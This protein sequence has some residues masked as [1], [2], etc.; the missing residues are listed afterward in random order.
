MTDEIQAVT[1]RIQKGQGLTQALLAHAKRENMKMSDGNISAAEWNLTIDKLIEIQNK[2]KVEGKASIFTGGTDRRDFKHSF[3]IH[4]NQEITF[5]KEEM[6]ELYSTMG[7]SFGTSESEQTGDAAKTD[8]TEANDATEQAAKADSTATEQAELSEENSKVDKTEQTQQ[9]QE[10]QEENENEEEP[11]TI[12][13]EL[14]SQIKEEDGKFTLHVSIG[15]P[16]YND[17]CQFDLEADSKEALIERAAKFEKLTEM[18]YHSHGFTGR[19]GEE[20]EISDEEKAKITEQMLE[21]LNSDDKDL[22]LAVAFAYARGGIL[23][24]NAKIFDAILAT[25]DPDVIVRMVANTESHCNMG[26]K[27]NVPV[28]NLDKMKQLYKL[29]KDSE[30]VENCGSDANYYQNII[31]KKLIN[32][33]AGNKLKNFAKQI[34]IEQNPIVRDGIYYYNFNLADA[35]EMISNSKKYKLSQENILNLAGCTSQGKGAY[36]ANAFR[37]ILAKISPNLHS[38]RRVKY[39]LSKVLESERAQFYQVK[40]DENLTN[41]IANYVL[42]HNLCEK[43]NGKTDWTPERKMEAARAYAREFKDDIAQKLGLKSADKINEGQIL[44]FGKVTQWPQPNWF[45]W[46][47]RY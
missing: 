42:A 12:S 35:D 30:F 31:A 47:F 37:K 36:T 7:V 26:E 38:D 40:K 23:N 41:I 27:G 2:R 24:D 45:N 33:T 19:G 46:T 3:V 8:S 32:I 44:D 17:S 28:E 10:V 34:Y 25:K 11:A 9:Q 43:I 21:Y 13:E 29:R 14:A 18:Y 22:K 20:Y 39:A 6:T 5:T 15:N 1:L 16:H 4:P